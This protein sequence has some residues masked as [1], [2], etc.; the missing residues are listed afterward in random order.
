MLYSILTKNENMREE[1]RIGLEK[2]RIETRINFPSMHLQPAY[3]EKYGDLKG[4]FPISEDVSKRIL[5][6]PIYINMT[7]AEQ[8][9][10]ANS[11]KNIVT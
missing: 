3:V 5:G 2:E 1:I 10:I 7:Q 9:L 11:I 4:K 6:L 8:E